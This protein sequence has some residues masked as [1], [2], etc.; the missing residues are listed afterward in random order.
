[1]ISNWKVKEMGRSREWGIKNV[2]RFILILFREY[3]DNN[4]L[5]TL[6]ENTV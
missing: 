5:E 2:L 3:I 1:M 6:T 4:Q